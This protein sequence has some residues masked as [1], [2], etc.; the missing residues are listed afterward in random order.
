MTVAVRTECQRVETV[1]VSVNKEIFDFDI[2]RMYLICHS[3][4]DRAFRIARDLITTGHDILCVSRY[5]PDIIRSMW[6]SGDFQSV[7]LSD[8]HHYGSI[9]ANNLPRLKQRIESYLS[10]NGGGVVMIDGIEYISL[11]NDFSKLLM[12][13]ESLNEMIMERHAILLIQVD[14]R[15]FDQRS[16][17]RLRRFAEI[18]H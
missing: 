14:P 16:L 9:P 4:S 2:G 15:S 17:A 3:R 8:R 6:E 10:S 1:C 12:F 13:I 5:H 18:V 11:F 7:W